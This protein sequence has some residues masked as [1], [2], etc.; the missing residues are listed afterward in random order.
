MK[1]K[2]LLFAIIA[3]GAWLT[4][5]S[6]IPTKSNIVLILSDDAGYADF[7]FQSNRFIA[8]PNIDRIANEGVKFTDAYVS[9]AV[10]APSRAGLLTGINQA[11]FGNVDNYIKGVK[12][13]I[14]QADYGIP[15]N[16]KLIGDY[17]HPHGYRT[18]II[19]KWHEGFSKPY[20][21]NSRG[22]DYFWGFLWGSSNYLPG[23]AVEVEE[24][25]Q[26]VDP[27]RIPY[28]TDAIG[29]H[30]LEFIEREQDHP[31]FLYVSF[32]AVHTPLQSKAEDL[33]KF[34]DQFKDK[35]KLNNAAMT[36]SLDQNVGRIFAQLEK[37]NLLDNTLIIFL[38]DNG[39]QKN[40]IHADNFPLRGQKSDPLE[41]G[42][43][44]P[45]AMRWPGKVEPGTV[46]SRIVSSLDIV[47]TAL[48]AA[49][50]KLSKQPQLK[51]K[52]LVEVASGKNGRDDRTLYWLISNDEGAI[53][54][55]DWKLVF[56]NGK[57]PQLYNLRRDIGESNDLFQSNNKMG[58]QLL[59]KY[60][61]WKSS[62]PPK[63]FQPIR[64]GDGSKD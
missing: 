14:P 10:C 37:L 4:F 20:H 36:H 39:G 18:G 54:Q 16:I 28:M 11:E 24:D 27:A 43:R 29:D 40:T 55:G 44:V 3:A 45:M 35:V 23:K 47:P 13:T 63:R 60:Q 25:G 26:P 42:I 15:Q 17:L 8:T 6:T 38:N 34:R 5:G 51:G 59:A 30:A 56:E 52:N 31:F 7:G 50:D 21:P 58:K 12:Y 19:G 64:P 57:G 2:I 48:A 9:A 32:N 41:G 53:R 61:G 1:K 49:G 22:F 33:E 62:L 46:S